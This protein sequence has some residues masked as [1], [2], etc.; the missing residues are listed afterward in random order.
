MSTPVGEFDDNEPLGH[1]PLK[2][3]SKWESQPEQ[4]PNN[5]LTKGDVTSP[6]G[7]MES[8]EPPSARKRQRS[9]FAGDV[10]I[11]E[12][13]NR[14]AQEPDRIREPPSPDSTISAF[15]AVGRIMGVIVVAAAGALGTL[16]GFEYLRGSAPP[17]E[18]ALASFAPLPQPASALPASA[19]P[20]SAPRAFVSRQ[21]DAAEIALM[22]KRGAEL[23]A[24]GNI[25]AARMMFLPAAELGEPVAAFALAET[26]D[27][28]VLRKLGA[29]GG[30]T[31][32][33]A[34]AQSW[35]EKAMK[36]GSAVAP[37]RLERLAR[38][39]E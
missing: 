17:Q 3:A 16:W 10:A 21:L 30:V 7:T 38:A 26:Y 4:D 12:L 18:I 24:N 22:M 36:L 11:A 1:V 34:L 32:D 8:P 33:A 5:A 20:A 14:L 6:P 35:Y 28:L 23:M 13:R 9:A 31:S 39:P 15:A 27:P 25:G 37:E 2:Y 19:S 29:K